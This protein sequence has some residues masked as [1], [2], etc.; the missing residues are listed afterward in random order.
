MTDISDT[1]ATA[2]EAGIKLGEERKERL[3]TDPEALRKIVANKVEVEDTV[4]VYPDKVVN[5]AFAKH[6]KELLQLRRVSEKGAG[7][8]DVAYAAR[9]AELAPTLEKLTA[10]GEQLRQQFEDSAVTLHFRGLGKKAIKRLQAQ[11]AK[12]FPLPPQGVQDDPLVAGERQDYYECSIIAAHIQ[13]NGFTLDDVQSW[14][15][16]WPNKAFGELWATAMRL[17]IADDYLAGVLD[18]DFS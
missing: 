13:H 1:E 17:S 6:E 18:V 3:L 10:E 8:A 2:V 4:T 11:A 12:E 16:A 7:E 15:D 9:I 5:L 14:K